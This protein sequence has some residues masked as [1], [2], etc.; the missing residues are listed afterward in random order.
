MKFVE[1]KARGYNKMNQ[2]TPLIIR[3]AVRAVLFDNQNKV[4]VLE[5]NGDGGIYYKIPGGT[6]EQG[7]TE[8]QAY[9]REMQEEAG[10]KV[11][12]I[13]ELGTHEFIV[14]KR[15]KQYKSKVFLAKVSGEKLQPKFD[16]WENKRGF[17]LLW[18]DKSD[19]LQKVSNIKTTNNYEI[20]IQKRDGDFLKKGIEIVNRMEN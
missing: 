1:I 12:I 9:D 11:K 8:I 19:A 10:C 4:A 14:K 20:I 16:D 5:V 15:N 18:L 2:K 17:K 6:I 7:E 13:K 3:N